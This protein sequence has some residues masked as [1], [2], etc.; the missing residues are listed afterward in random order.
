MRTKP[1]LAIVVVGDEAASASFIRAKRRYGQDVGVEV[2]VENAKSSAELS[3][4]LKR[5]NDDNQVGGIVLQLPL[6]KDFDTPSMIKLI[7]PAKDIDGL[8]EGVKFESATAKAI[9]WILASQGLNLKESQV[10]VV[11]QGK[12]VGAP[13]SAMLEASGIQVTRCDEHT[14]DLSAQTKAANIVISGVGKPGLITRSML[15]D[16]V[17]VVDAGTAEARG[18]LVGDVDPALYDDPAVKVT[19]VPGGVG[20][21]TVAALFDNLLIATSS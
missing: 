4:A 6:P 16:G 9:M 20:P 8:G 10:C 1:V 12:L 5:L 13:V 21:A 17:I 11:G 19:P 3:T 2:Q 7:N 14:K 15:K 18:A